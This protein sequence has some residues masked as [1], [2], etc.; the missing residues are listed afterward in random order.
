MILTL[1]LHLTLV[2]ML[3]VVSSPGIRC[4]SNILKKRITDGFQ[5]TCEKISHF[6]RWE[7]NLYEWHINRWKC[8]VINLG[9]KVKFPFHVKIFIFFHR[10]FG[11]HKKVVSVVHNLLS[12]HDSDPRYADPEVKARVAMLYLPLIGIIM[13]TLPQL[14]DFTGKEIFTAVLCSTAA[15]FFIYAVIFTV[16]HRYT[17]LFNMLAVTTFVMYNY[18]T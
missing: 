17:S 15:G 6:L 8:I 14:H 16:L 5:T 4:Q 3:T 12:S 9:N 10:M 11:L 7:I 18:C 13:E 2:R 1:Q